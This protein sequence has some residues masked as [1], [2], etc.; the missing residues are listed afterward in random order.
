MLVKYLVC[1]FSPHCS[2]WLRVWMC[3]SQLPTGIHTLTQYESIGIHACTCIQTCTHTYI[4][5]ACML[6]CMSMYVPYRYSRLKVEANCGI[7]FW[8]YLDWFRSKESKIFH[9]F[10][11]DITELLSSYLGLCNIRQRSICGL[12]VVC[13]LNYFL[14]RYDSLLQ[15]IG[16]VE[17][18]KEVSTFFYI[19]S[20]LFSRGRVTLISLWRLSKWVLK[21]EVDAALPRLFS[22]FPF[23]G[24]LNLCFKSWKGFGYPYERGD[25][26]HESGIHGLQIS[27]NQSTSLA[28]GFVIL[29][30]IYSHVLVIHACMHIYTL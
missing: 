8:F 16:H 25:K 1:I 2:M 28:Q 14:A 10:V 26:V 3:K 11:P 13:W 5:C 30:C 18:R 21:S 29:K 20:S 22:F 6:V 12:L 15:Q 9:I 7:Q 4:K 23:W 19:N 17:N 24:L 27:T